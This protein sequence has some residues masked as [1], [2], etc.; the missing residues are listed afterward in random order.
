MA[1]GPFNH[2]LIEKFEYCDENFKNHFSIWYTEK[3]DMS[4]QD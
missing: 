4:I 3:A 2:N 1:D